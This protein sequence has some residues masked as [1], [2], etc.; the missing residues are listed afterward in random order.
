MRLSARW[1]TLPCEHTCRHATA[2]WAFQAPNVELW[3]LFSTTRC[4]CVGNW[5][6][7]LLRFERCSAWSAGSRLRFS[8]PALWASRLHR[9][10]QQSCS[11]LFRIGGP[12][13][14]SCRPCADFQAGRP[15][16]DVGSALEQAEITHFTATCW[17]CFEAN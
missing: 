5:G 17:R 13:A 6:W 10:F 7:F 1:N 2:P 16:N 8:W 15:L 4:R 11:S 12:S 9:I 14:R 3:Y